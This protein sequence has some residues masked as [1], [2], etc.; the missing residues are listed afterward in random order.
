MSTLSSL[1][2]KEAI[3]VNGDIESNDIVTGSLRL[4][5]GMG[6]TK[7]MISNSNLSFDGNS[8]GGITTTSMSATLDDETEIIVTGTATISLPDTTTFP[9]TYKGVVYFIT[10]DIESGPPFVVTVDTPNT[11]T[12][13]TM[14]SLTSS[15]TIDG[16]YL[17]TVIISNIENI[18]YVTNTNQDSLDIGEPTAVSATTGVGIGS[19][20][21]IVSFTEPVILKTP[22]LYYVTTSDPGDISSIGYKSP[23][24]TTGLTSGIP[25]T[26]QVRS[27]TK[28]TVGT[29]SSASN[30][31]TPV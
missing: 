29:Q 26:F 2:V 16:S 24:I 6:V 30:Q 20:N 28:Y 15:F 1:L 27:V 19:G 14:G 13:L 3:Y 23:I 12:I 5:G 8:S 9:N 11:N 17:S 21:A 7:N 4:D 31:V 18:W 25:Y 10:K 22:V